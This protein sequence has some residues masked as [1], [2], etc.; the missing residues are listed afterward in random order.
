[1]SRRG[2]LG[3]VLWA[4]LAIPFKLACIGLMIALPLIGVW[5][6]SS[7]ALFKNQSLAWSIGA[8]LLMFPVLPL[9]WEGFAHW[10]RSRK[11]NVGPRHL[12][13]LDR[14]ILR[15][16]V[17]NGLFIG[18]LLAT[19][20]QA[21]FTALSARGDWM[22]AGRS[23][24]RVELVRGYLFRAADTLE[25]LYKLSK[26]NPYEKYKD[27]K[28]TPTPKPA[29]VADRDKAGQGE[30]QQGKSETDT[31]QTGQEQDATPAAPTWPEAPTLH[32]LVASFPP[33]EEKSPEH[34]G[35]YIGGRIADPRERAR[36][37][38]DYVADRVAY[39]VPALRSGS[40]PPQDAETV[41]RTGKGVC[42]GYAKLFEAVGRA[43]GLEAVY[44]VGDVRNETGG[45]DGV[46][47]AWNA[48]KIG[49][50]W[51]LVDVTWD[52]GFVNGES[53]TKR[54][55]TVYFLTPPEV[56]ST[57]H[58]PESEEWQLREKPITRGDFIRQPMMRPSFYALGLRLH[59]PD[60]SQVSVT[61]ALSIGVV[62]PRGI[63]FLVKYT[64]SGQEGASGTECQVQP[65]R[66]T[67]MLC[68]FKQSGSYDVKLFV[69]PRQYGSY[70]Y[71]GKVM[72][73]NALD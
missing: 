1:M 8:G 32:P 28:Q 43:A 4:L 19:N 73:N 70:E 64:P 10:R 66:V 15:T 30:S 11:R 6:A 44:V 18:A 69:S 71:V 40:F 33:Q 42:A 58:F 38:H 47:H 57:D 13:G 14:L 56:F 24:P 22:L 34:V 16:V 52:A 39:D 60:R 2:G 41:L 3:T 23:G 46:G 54:L 72:A 55:R 9:L 62:N 12:N 31:G 29:P 48:V 5:V 65:D 59:H 68:T 35:R 50:R 37:I 61:G 26:D 53:Y 49:E 67:T 45:I 20:P 17:I 27:K 63:F 7:L 36:A 21:G 51:H 25:W